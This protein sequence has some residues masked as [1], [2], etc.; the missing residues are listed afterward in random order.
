MNK[1]YVADVWNAHVSID[2]SVTMWCPKCGLN[3]ELLVHTLV[4][5]RPDQRGKALDNN[6]ISIS[7]DC[8]SNCLKCGT[9]MIDM[10]AKFIEVCEKLRVLGVKVLDANS[11]YYTPHF[12]DIPDGIVSDTYCSGA[13]ITIVLDHSQDSLHG[14]ALTITCCE[15]EEFDEL[16]TIEINED[17]DLGGIVITSIFD[18][19]EAKCKFGFVNKEKVGGDDKLKMYCNISDDRLLRFLEDF[20]ENIEG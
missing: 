13:N 2:K 9:R 19:V 3:E 6:S 15:N 8:K 16:R 20:I 5:N 17:H 4:Q 1:N 14:E 12:T 18:L 10:D 11:A 7:I